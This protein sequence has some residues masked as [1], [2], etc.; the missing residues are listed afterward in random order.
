MPLRGMVWI[1]FFSPKRIEH[2]K[3]TCPGAGRGRGVG[4]CGAIVSVFSATPTPQKAP[5]LPHSRLRRPPEVVPPV[6]PRLSR[7][8]RL[9][10]PRGRGRGKASISRE[11]TESQGGAQGGRGGDPDVRRGPW[12]SGRPCAT[13]IA[14]EVELFLKLQEVLRSPPQAR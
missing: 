11:K 9:L 8:E 6:N 7:Q 4:V 5:P 2:T 14:A 13:W 3:K 1:R 10:A 12:P